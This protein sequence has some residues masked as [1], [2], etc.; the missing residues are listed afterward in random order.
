MA[1]PGLPQGQPQGAAPQDKSKFVDDDQPNVSP[2]EQAQYDQFMSNALKLIY[3]PEGVRPE[4]LQ[5]LKAG[6]GA[7]AAATA[8]SAQQ[9]PP[10]QG[11]PQGDQEQGEAPDSEQAEGEP[12]AGDTEQGE[13]PDAE[14]PEGE[15]SAQGGKPSA[16]IMALASAAVTIVSQL[17]DSARK[18]GKPISD[19]VLFHGGLDVVQELAEVA[20]A[21]KIHDYSQEDI[22]G[23]F[24]Q[25]VDQY[26]A[27]AVS[28]G[29]TTDDTLK[30]QFGE[31][32]QADQEGKLGDILPGL[33]SGPPQGEPPVQSQGG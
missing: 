20:D 15:A 16:P 6:Q 28:D 18:A 24:A 21:A 31:I 23:A 2:E 17:D 14:Q 3:T 22:T 19:D 30:Q 25:A 5:A 11:G 1:L 13:A 32:N 4:V 29:R 7:P 9:Q 33:S 8:P 10:P 12:P 26:R 27:K